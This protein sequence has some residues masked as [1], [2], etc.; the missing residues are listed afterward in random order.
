M[1]ITVSP[2]AGDG[3]TNPALRVNYQIQDTYVA[4]AIQ[5]TYVPASLAQTPPFQQV[6]IPFSAT[7][8]ASATS[9]GYPNVPGSGSNY[10]ILYLTI[11]GG[12]ATVVTA[13]GTVSVAA[14]VAA[15]P[16]GAILILTQGPLTFS[17]T[18]ASPALWPAIS[19]PWLGN[20]AP[21]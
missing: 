14:L 9:P 16:A 7:V 19:F 12:V 11:S 1:P 8:A 18:P 21:N 17:V 13:Q 5:G 2:A 15:M 4:T 6:P 20:V 10:W 3:I